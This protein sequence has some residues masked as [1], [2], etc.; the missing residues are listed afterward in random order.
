MQAARLYHGRA[1]RSP[2]DPRVL[3]LLIGSRARFSGLEGSNRAGLLG[4]VDLCEFAA[5]HR[6]PSAQTLL[7]DF[8]DS[9]HIR[10]RRLGQIREARRRM[11]M[12]R[13]RASEARYISATPRARPDYLRNRRQSRSSCIRETC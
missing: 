12:A 5:T 8:G 9:V 10:P 7:V 4:P 3:S 2:R 13:E 1:I 11:N 6:L